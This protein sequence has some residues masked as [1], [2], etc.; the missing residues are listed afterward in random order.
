MK[1]ISILYEHN[2]LLI[3]KL[4]HATKEQAIMLNL[5][6]THATPQSKDRR[7]ILPSLIIPCLTLR[8]QECNPDKDAIANI[9]QIHDQ[10]KNYHTT[11]TL[12]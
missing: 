11:I 3:T 8:T 1:P 4:T 9:A 2:L 6:H 10:D 7:N 12:K 5:V